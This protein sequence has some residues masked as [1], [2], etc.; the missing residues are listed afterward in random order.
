MLT[1]AAN[2]LSILLIS[3]DF[4]YSLS[5]DTLIW[6]FPEIV[7][8]FFEVEGEGVYVVRA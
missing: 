1:A 3:N 4:R 5:Y 6:V 8:F 2:R 7:S